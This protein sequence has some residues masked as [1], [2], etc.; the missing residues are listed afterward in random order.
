MS[1]NLKTET[2]MSDEIKNEPVAEAKPAEELSVEE[3]N[4]VNGGGIL[5]DIITAVT[6]A[7]GNVVSPRDASTGLPSGKR[8]Y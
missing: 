3:L 4:K 7:G 2:A 1:Q 6:G 5:S 8:I